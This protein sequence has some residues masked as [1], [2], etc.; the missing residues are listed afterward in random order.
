MKAVP[1]VQID[2]ESEYDKDLDTLANNPDFSVSNL[3]KRLRSA[4]KANTQ[5][6]RVQR[7]LFDSEVDTEVFFTQLQEV[8]DGFSY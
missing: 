6:R 2:D 1:V 8:I 4:Q 3:A 5:L 7:E